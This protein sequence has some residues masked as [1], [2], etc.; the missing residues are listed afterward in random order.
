MQRVLQFF[1]FFLYAKQANVVFRKIIHTTITLL[2]IVLLIFTCNTVK[3][4]PDYP[5][6]EHP[7]SGES[8][9]IAWLAKGD[10]LSVGATRQFIESEVFYKNLFVLYLSDTLFT[11]TS[12]TL[13]YTNYGLLPIVRTLSNGNT[14]VLMGFV[15]D[16]TDFAVD[17][18]QWVFSP[19]ALL[20]SDTLP[21]F[22]GNHTDADKDGIVEFSG[23]IST[24]APYCF[25]CDSDYY[26][27]RLFYEMTSLG[28]QL[29]SSATRQWAQK[30]YGTF[31]GLKPDSTQILPLLTPLYP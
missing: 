6:F 10:T 14:E 20:S 13:Y 18:L 28:M 15:S 27:P 8:E 7:E 19:T 17:M 9:Q 3:Q 22:D 5:Y 30:T 31:L 4:T 23:F 12:A 24:L 16:N 21:L 26:R 25:G 2:L 29:D 11:D 1:D